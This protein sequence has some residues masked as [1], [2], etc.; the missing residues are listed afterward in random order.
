M[1]R[2]LLAIVIVY[3][4]VFNAAL[5]YQY[6][7]VDADE[8][9]YTEAAFNFVRSGND[10]MSSLHGVMHMDEEFIFCGKLTTALHSMVIY[11][12]GYGLIQ[13]RLLSFS[14]AVLNILLSFKIAELITDKRTAFL[15]AIALILCI[16]MLPKKSGRP[17]MLIMGGVLLTI[18][19]SLTSG[20]TRPWLAGLVS[21]I[22][23][24]IHLPTAPLTVIVAALAYLNKP[25]KSLPVL[26]A[27]QFAGFL[28]F[29]SLIVLPNFTIY[30]TQI[31]EF[32]M[33]FYKGEALGLYR[34]GALLD[35][36]S[37]FFFSIGSGRNA[38]LF[39]LLVFSAAILIRH[40]KF[41][42]L[43]WLLYCLA[44]HVV[45]SLQSPHGG[46]LYWVLYLPLIFMVI[47]EAMRSLKRFQT[48]LLVILFCYL[49]A[50]GML[51]F[52]KYGGDDHN[53]RYEEFARSFKSGDRVLGNMRIRLFN[54][55]IAVFNYVYI[56]FDNHPAFVS[57]YSG[58]LSGD[59]RQL[60]G[61]LGI[62]HI[63]LDDEFREA[64]NTVSESYKKSFYDYLTANTK[65]MNS[66]VIYGDTRDIYKVICR[67]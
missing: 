55:D 52:A 36:L 49:F 16:D 54:T 57:K 44:G 62:T 59:F 20:R 23:L 8:V 17:D 32:A 50:S 3:A 33:G 37:W 34:I 6:P 58:V 27:G 31:G 46:R 25:F 28:I 18:L 43:K 29:A 30:M 51:L 41:A 1:Q 11:L 56:F 14:I 67:D 19:V 64:L 2:S 13:V 9:G 47:C 63:A 45:I 38:P 39:L 12:F 66:C 40:K 61:K 21:T 4:V 53:E 22:G 7:R 5:F 35:G 60:P 15:T 42:V 48:A 26:L 65:L 10:G 24:W